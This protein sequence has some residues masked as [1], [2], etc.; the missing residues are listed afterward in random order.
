MRAACIGLRYPND[1]LSLVAVAI[2]SGRMTHHNPTAYLGSLVAA[3]FASLAIRKE[4]PNSWVSR[5][6]KEAL[7]LAKDYVSKG[8]LAEDN[9]AVWDEFEQHWRSYATKR[10]LSCT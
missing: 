9:L 4:H 10:G 2:E 1:L 8:R 3:Y 7:P 5:L 6:L